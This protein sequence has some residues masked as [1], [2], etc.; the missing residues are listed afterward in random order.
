M[1]VRGYYLSVK[2]VERGNGMISYA[3]FSGTTKLL[4]QVARKSAKAEREAIEIAARMEADVIAEVLE[5][6][7]LTIQNY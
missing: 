3:M 2:P 4:N 5:K 6:E 1:R 7:K